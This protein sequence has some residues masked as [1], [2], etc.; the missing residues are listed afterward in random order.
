MKLQRES[1]LFYRLRVS[2][3][4]QIVKNSA[5]R[6]NNCKLYDS[7]FPDKMIWWICGKSP[8]HFKKEKCVHAQSFSHGLFCDPMDCSLPGTS[9]CG[10]LQARILE[11]VA[12]PFSR[13][14]SRPRDWTWV[15]GLSCTGRWILY[16]WATWE[17]LDAIGQQQ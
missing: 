8:S 2:C 11:W 1:Y 4:T 5:S 3:L 6:K 16:H 12:I 17:I 14:S 10:I 15:S 9:V 7:N 13:G